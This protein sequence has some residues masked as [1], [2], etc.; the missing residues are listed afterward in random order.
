MKYQT[1]DTITVPEELFLKS[2]DLNMANS[3]DFLVTIVMFTIDLSQS[4]CKQSKYIHY[5]GH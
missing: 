2:L 4:D 5:F 1:K 3:I